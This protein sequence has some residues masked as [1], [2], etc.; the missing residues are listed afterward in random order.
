MP[1][2]SLRKTLFR[3]SQRMLKELVCPV[4]KKVHRTPIGLG[5][6]MQDFHSD[7]SVQEIK[8]RDVANRKK[9]KTKKPVEVYQSDSSLVN[10]DEL[11]LS[12]NEEFRQDE[13][14]DL[15]K[16]S[17]D[18][19]CPIHMERTNDVGSVDDG[20]DEILISQDAIEIVDV[21]KELN[22]SNGSN[23]GPLSDFNDNSDSD[24]EIIEVVDK[25]DNFIEKRIKTYKKLKMTAK[26]YLQKLSVDD[27]QE[28]A[29]VSIHKNKSKVGLLQKK[30]AG[31]EF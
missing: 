24:I 9:T 4:C 16:S 25:C 8:A 28:F 5:I 14:D 1:Q 31:D 11:L 21:M 19:L 10:I 15:L 22:Q 2:S 23:V 30:K 3:E 26:V 20:H 13:I 6:H 27:P 29:D 18:E 17:G 7:L 12:D